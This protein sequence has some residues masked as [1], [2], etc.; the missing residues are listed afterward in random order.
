[1]RTLQRRQPTSKSLSASTLPIGTV[2]VRPYLKHFLSATHLPFPDVST[3][4]G[5]IQRYGNQA[6][7]FKYNNAVFVSTFIGDG[8][9][10]RSVESQSGIKLFSC[11][12]WQPSSLSSSS[13]DCGFSW[14]AWPSSNN[15]PINQN[16]T[17]AS[18][19]A[20]VSALGAKPYMMRM[21]FLLVA[22]AICL[23]FA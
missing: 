14:D 18:D 11:L 6:A 17:T 9:D 13:A 3:I 8:F 4:A 16:K 22:V 1:M 10:W 23:T 7:Q 19:N 2:A 5:Y 12:N 20:Y 15:Q 21:S